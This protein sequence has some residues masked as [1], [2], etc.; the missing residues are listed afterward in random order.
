M[1]TLPAADECKP[2]AVKQL[3]EM[4]RLQFFLH[5]SARVWLT[6]LLPVG[7]FCPQ[8]PLNRTYWF[9][10][11][12]LEE[13]KWRAKFLEPFIAR[14]V[15]QTARKLSAGPTDPL[16]DRSGCEAADTSPRYADTPEEVRATKAAC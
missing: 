3:L 15:V 8:A 13:V 7:L 2:I 4:L 1:A 12:C 14:G 9:L 5:L 10:H 6:R 11:S 16:R